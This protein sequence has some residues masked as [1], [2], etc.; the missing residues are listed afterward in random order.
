MKILMPDEVE[1]KN[2]ITKKEL[3]IIIVALDRYLEYCSLKSKS[4]LAASAKRKIQKTLDKM[5]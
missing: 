5:T 1:E 2:I 3:D 4:D